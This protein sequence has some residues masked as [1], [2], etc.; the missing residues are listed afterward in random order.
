MMK[1]YVEIISYACY[2][3]INYAILRDK[4]DLN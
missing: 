4:Q 3:D 1:H 2:C